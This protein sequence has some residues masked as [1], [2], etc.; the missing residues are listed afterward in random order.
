MRSVT[1]LLFAA[2]AIV[3]CAPL[4]AQVGVPPDRS[5]FRDLE[6][7]MEV[8]LLAGWFMAGDDPVGV[9]PN[10]GVYLGGRY[11]YSLGALVSLF[12]RAGIVPTTRSVIDPEL[13]AATRVI[14]EVEQTIL[15][16]DA[17]LSFHPVGARSYRRLVPVFS[18]GLGI[19]TG[20]QARDAGGY[21]LTPRV[22]L[23]YGAGIKW[24][25]GETLQLR[26]DITDHR[27]GIRYPD[28]YLI[29]ASDGTSARTGDASVYTSNPTLS[30]G[31]SRRF[32]R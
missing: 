16:A 23:T 26:V 12:G 25:A 11:D 30:L 20:L 7:R 4:S 29:P 3:Y 9:G 14:G 21:D 5:P 22:L 6:H 17:G 32:F 28:S 15:L 1:R 24:L 31:L 19:S 18:L 13:P 8:G 10:P 27:L 2:C